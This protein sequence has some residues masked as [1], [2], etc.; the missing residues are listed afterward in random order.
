MSLSGTGAARD[1]FFTQVNREVLNGSCYAIT[2][3]IQGGRVP[4]WS[5][6]LSNEKSGLP[7]GQSS[8]IAGNRVCATLRVR[9][10]AGERGGV[11]LTAWTRVLPTDL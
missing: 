2:L 5:D 7:Q 10:F 1:M 4:L 6:L 8:A 3:W 11:K 9:P